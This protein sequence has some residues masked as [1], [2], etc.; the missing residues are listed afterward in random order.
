MSLEALRGSSEDTTQRDRARA[1]QNTPHAHERI[2]ETVILAIKSM[3]RSRRHYTVKKL[4]VSKFTAPDD[5]VTVTSLYAAM[6]L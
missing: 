3:K 6:N 1:H 4:H 2:R 5:D